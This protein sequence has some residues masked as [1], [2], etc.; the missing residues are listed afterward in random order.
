MTCG[1]ES[2]EDGG[3]GGELPAGAD[4]GDVDADVGA[5]EVAHEGGVPQHEH[6]EE[7]QGRQSG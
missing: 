2:G 1:L 6:Q 5:G 4:W 7:D 3:A